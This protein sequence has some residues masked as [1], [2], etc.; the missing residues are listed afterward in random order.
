[1]RRITISD[2]CNKI[3]CQQWFEYG[4]IIIENNNLIPEGKL[5]VLRLHNYMIY[6]WMVRWVNDWNIVWYTC[7]FSMQLYPFAT[8]VSFLLSNKNGT[9][10]K[11]FSFLV[12]KYQY[13]SFFSLVTTNDSLSIWTYQRTKTVHEHAHNLL[14]S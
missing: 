8:L 10:K 9:Y 14:D 5:Y 7:T 13:C 2:I 11:Y 3:K 6:K 12:Y 4:N 1:M